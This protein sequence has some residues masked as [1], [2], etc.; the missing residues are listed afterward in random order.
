MASLN[1]V[2]LIGNVARDPELRYINDGTP[3]MDL[4]LAVTRRAKTSDG[5]YKDDTA[6]IDVTVW[7]KAAENCAEYLSKGSSVF[8]EGHLR[9]DQWEDKK[10]G[11]KRSKLRVT[12]ERVQFLDRRFSGGGAPGGTGAPAPPATPPPSPAPGPT[13]PATEE[14]ALSDDD[15]PF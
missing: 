13:A 6:F 8:I 14:P 5:S 12:A 1:K 2:F 11:E 4:R 7:R 3:V 9:M 10:T 15:I